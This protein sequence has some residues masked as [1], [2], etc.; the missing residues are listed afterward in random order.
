MNEH[1]TNTT[2]K[3]PYVKPRLEKV[4]LLPDQAVL[5]ACK[6]SLGISP[7]NLGCVDGFGTACNDFSS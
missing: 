6:N 3:I 1:N 2:K 7:G 4:K 5:S